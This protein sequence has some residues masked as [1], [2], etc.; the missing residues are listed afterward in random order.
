[1][2]MRTLYLLESLGE[3]INKRIVKT[4]EAR[5]IC[6]THFPSGMRKEQGIL[7]FDILLRMPRQYECYIGGVLNNNKEISG[8]QY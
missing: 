3:S 2:F 7:S 5:L 1:M 6:Q 8:T 4:S